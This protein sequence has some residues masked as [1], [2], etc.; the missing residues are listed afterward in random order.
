MASPQKP[1]KLS[2]AEIKAR[3]EAHPMAVPFLW[4][5]DPK[6]VKNFIWVPFIGLIIFSILGAIF[7]MYKKAPWDF[8]AS[9][10]LIGFVAY[11][12]VV[13]ASRPLFKVLSRPED[14]YGEGDE[15]D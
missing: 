14:Y 6:V 5:A 9:Y 4:L 11:S 15:N 12:F 13:L 8:F 10:T 3:A 1:A 7:P 2:K